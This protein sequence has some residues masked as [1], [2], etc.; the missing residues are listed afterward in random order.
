MLWWAVGKLRSSNAV[1]RP[2]S[3]AALGTNL[4]RRAIEPLAAAPADE[5]A[6][7]RKAASDALVRIDVID[8][9]AGTV[10]LRNIF[11]HVTR[12]CNLR[13]SYCYLAAGQPDRNELRTAELTRLWSQIVAVRP[14]K[15]VFTGGEPLLRPDL[16]TL[17]AGLKLADPEHLVL[18]C[19]NTNGCLV[20][21]E[22][23]EALVG[24]ADEVRVSVDGLGERN[25]LQRGEG[26]F[27][28]AVRAL[29]TLYSVGFEPIAMLTL[30][31]EGLAGIEG[32]LA[33]LL[34]RRITRIHLNPFRAIGRGA[35]HTDW[36]VEAEEARA[37]LDRAWTRMFGKVA[38]P[39]GPPSERECVN[40]GVGKF[41][42]ILPEGDVYPCH[43]LASPRF[44]LGNVRH[45][46]LADLCAA[47]GLLDRMQRL[48]FRTLADTDPRWKPLAKPGACLGS[49]SEC[50]SYVPI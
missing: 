48:N 24:L 26:S 27:E 23:A 33:Y 13:C 34:E 50:S 22:L 46:S 10:P 7:V 1:T 20:T 30:T 16:C 3:A 49:V 5:N 29:Q 38:L 42:N 19:L 25:N 8:P 2:C 4:D 32:L 17:L 6:E 21:R 39:T 37:A 36:R 47:G 41:L 40:C 28:A 43:V 12:A 35:G 14:R 9:P 45:D 15:V 31:R 18:R 11:L 44:R